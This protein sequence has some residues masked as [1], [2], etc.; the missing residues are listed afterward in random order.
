MHFDAAFDKGTSRSVSGVVVW[1]LRDEFLASKTVLHNNVPSP[2]AAEAYV[3]LEAIKLG[4][5][6]GF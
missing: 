4:I 1:G 5:S 2:F 3:G 6:M